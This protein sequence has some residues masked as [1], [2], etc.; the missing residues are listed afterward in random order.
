MPEQ[1]FLTAFSNKSWKLKPDFIVESEIMQSMKAE[2]SM[3]VM[4]TISYT[5]FH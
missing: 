2:L 1:R 4:M 5:T 3:A